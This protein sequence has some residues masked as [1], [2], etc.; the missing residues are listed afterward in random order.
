MGLA[1]V[2]FVFLVALAAVAQS[3]VIRSADDDAAVAVDAKGETIQMSPHKKE[4]H[5]EAVMMALAEKNI[6]EILES[7]GKQTSGGKKLPGLD[8]LKKNW[9]NFDLDRNH[10]LTAVDLKYLLG[11]L[12]KK[13][14][15]GL[16]GSPDGSNF[17]ERITKDFIASMDQDGDGKVSFDDYAMFTTQM[18]TNARFKQKMEERQNALMVDILSD[19]IPG[20]KEKIADAKL[21][22]KAETKVTK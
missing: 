19:E 7:K 2:S 4:H 13:M 8:Q 22:Q 21:A 6:K 11:S 3:S 20:L 9:A 1:Q 5:S 14:G 18:A 16:D 15:A 10:E 17:Q 12:T